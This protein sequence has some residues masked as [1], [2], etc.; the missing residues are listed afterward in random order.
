M[1]KQICLEPL[2]GRRLF[3][4]GFG[5]G[6]F[7]ISPPGG[8]QGHETIQLHPEQG[9]NGLRTATAQSGGV[10][11]WQLTVMHEWTPGDHAGP[12]QFAPEL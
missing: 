3:A 4:A 1:S 8:G 6:D 11:N 9:L 5:N 10:V 2:E 12:H 7:Q